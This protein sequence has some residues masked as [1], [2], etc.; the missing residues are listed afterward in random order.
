M[1][2]LVSVGVPASP[3]S[4][5]FTSMSTGVSTGVWAA[6]SAAT[7]TTTMST[8]AV[9]HSGGDASSQTRTVRVSGPV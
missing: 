1:G 9:S 5:A 2:G 7:G 8:V 4:F 3:K 6:S